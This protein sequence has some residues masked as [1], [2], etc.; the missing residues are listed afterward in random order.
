MAK[1][2]WLSHSSGGNLSPSLGVAH[3][4]QER[5]HEVIFVTRPEATSRVD[6]EGL[7]AIAL[8]KAYTRLSDYPDIGPVKSV[9]CALTSPDVSEELQAVIE[10]ESPDALIVDA[11]YPAALALVPSCAVPVAVFCHTFL[12]R[13]FQRWQGIMGKLADLRAG[14]GFPSLPAMET[15]WKAA[16][17]LIVTAAEAL[18]DKPLKGWGNVVHVG[19]SLMN[20]A[21][22]MPCDLPWA[23]DDTTPLVLA[24]FTT[25]ELAS[26]GPFEVVLEALSD[27][28]VHVVATT[29]VDVDL[30]PPANAHVIRYADHNQILDRASLCVC[31]GGHGTTMRALAHGV[32]MVVRPG[33]PH[34]QAP[35]AAFVQSLGAGRAVPG[36]ADAPTIR[37]AVLEVLE[38]PSYLS[39]A[40]QIKEVLDP[41]N[42]PEAAATAVED[43][44]RE[45]IAMDTL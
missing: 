11:M 23:E 45:T 14:A 12:W 22:A 36:D 30:T 21:H 4:L 41:L 34:D 40:R 33:M 10:A 8:T 3:I 25:T 13:H 32:P 27:L 5:G 20:E 31:H 29:A 37:A 17:R 38:D 2:L 1:I 43:L 16:D 26:G 42:G 9:F 19:P 7:S 44:I 35:N 28:P 39:A 24:S 6:A 18:D 15:M